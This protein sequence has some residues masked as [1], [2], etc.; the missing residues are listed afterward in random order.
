M[1]IFSPN[2]Q[3]QHCQLSVYSLFTSLPLEWPNIL[4]PHGAGL[5]SQL[6]LATSLPAC[7]FPKSPPHS[8]GFNFCGTMILEPTVFW[9]VCLFVCFL[10]N[11]WPYNLCGTQK[12]VLTS[13]LYICTCA[14]WVAV[15]MSDCYPMY[16]SPPD[17]SVMDSLGK[18]T[19][20]GCHGLLQGIFPTQGSNAHLLCLLHWQAG[21][22]YHSGHLGS[23]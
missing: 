18:N 7:Q 9:P 21:V 10:H 19:G 3:A 11:K 4:P 1:K 14:C 20:V 16:C 17:S 8:L 12:Q 22:L 5:F 2:C 6:H 23:P 15:V 13:L